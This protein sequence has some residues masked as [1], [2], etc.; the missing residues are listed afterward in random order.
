MGV[1]GYPWT[2]ISLPLLIG[3]SALSVVLYSPAAFLGKGLH[4]KDFFWV[5][6]VDP[7]TGENVS[8]NLYTTES[9]PGHTSAMLSQASRG[10]IETMHLFRDPFKRVRKAIGA[11]STTTTSS[12]D[13]SQMRDL[14]KIIIP[15]TSKQTGGAEK[16]SQYMSAEDV[17]SLQAMYELLDMLLRRRFLLDL[18][19][20]A[21]EQCDDDETKRGMRAALV[22]KKEQLNELSARAKEKFGIPDLA[23]M[24][25]DID[26]A[27]L[28]NRRLS[29]NAKD[30][31]SVEARN[32]DSNLLAAAQNRLFS[33]VKVGGTVLTAKEISSNPGGTAVVLLT[34]NLSLVE[35]EM[36]ENLNFVYGCGDNEKEEK[37]ISEYHTATFIES[38]T[39]T[40]M[41]AVAISLPLYALY[42]M[43]KS[44][45]DS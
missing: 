35:R 34:Q 13:Q 18:T 10:A 43:V 6:R 20:A 16:P 30:A 42:Y 3:V 15:T 28:A 39:R 27:C 9:V 33:D 21:V 36:L 12:A 17:Q 1:P 8:V 44:K 14:S 45:S 24:H 23:R 11:G 19:P 5:A 7:T 29:R 37:V 40:S 2:S 22:N 32:K 31:S 38:V 41:W 25:K 4:M 26:I